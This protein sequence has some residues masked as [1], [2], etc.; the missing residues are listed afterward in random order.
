MTAGKVKQLAICVTIVILSCG[1]LGRK[2]TLMDIVPDE[3]MR[4]TDSSF[5]DFWSSVITEQGG[6]HREIHYNAI[7]R[8]QEQVDSVE[9]FWGRTF[10]ALGLA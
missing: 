4:E 2:H 8:G 9:E 10:P 6:Q 7:H 5:S 1:C 3:G